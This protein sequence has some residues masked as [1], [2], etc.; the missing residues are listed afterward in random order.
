MPAPEVGAREGAVRDRPLL[1]RVLSSHRPWPRSPDVDWPSGH[2]ERVAPEGCLTGQTPV[3]AAL[4]EKDG[5]D[6]DVPRRACDAA[7]P[8]GLPARAARR[9]RRAEEG[10]RVEEM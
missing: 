2:G 6:P 10:L 4:L 8:P 5:A 9:H 7:R 1:I 3:V